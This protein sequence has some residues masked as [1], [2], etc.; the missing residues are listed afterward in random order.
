[1]RDDTKMN[2]KCLSPGGT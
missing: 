2:K 1:M